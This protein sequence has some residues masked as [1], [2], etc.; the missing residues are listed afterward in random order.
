[1]WRKVGIPSPFSDD[2]KTNSGNAAG[3]L[4]TILP[5]SDITSSKSIF[6]GLSAFVKTTWK[7]TADLP[8]NSI[9]SS[10]TDFT[11]C[12]ESISKKTR[13]NEALPDK[14]AFNSVCHFLTTGNGA[15]AKPYPG[16]STK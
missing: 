6:L 16:T 7:V 9:I 15:F 12:R 8:N 2:V 14:Y 13:R 4:A 5:V 11:P 10:S 1:M 3:Y